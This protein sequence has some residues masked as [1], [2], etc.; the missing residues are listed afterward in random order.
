MQCYKKR[1]EN[2]DSDDRSS[3]DE[4]RTEVKVVEHRWRWTSC[5]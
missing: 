5:D 2:M 3:G 4:T 1:K